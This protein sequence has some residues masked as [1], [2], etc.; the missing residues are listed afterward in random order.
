MNEM[1]EIL[2]YVADEYKPWVRTL[3]SKDVGQI[4]NSI[5]MMPNIRDS[6][7]IISKGSV[8]IGKEGENTFMQIITKY[9]SDDYKLDNVTKV[10]HSGDF[11]LI[12][13]S[14]KTNI[15]YK[16]LI[17]VKQYTNTVPTREITK[18]YTDLNQN[19]IHC[20]LFISL[21]SK[22]CGIS[23]IVELKN[24]AKDNGQPIPCIFANIKEPA[25]IVEIIK[26]LFHIV[27]INDI[28]DNNVYRMDEL[29]YQLS[30]LN[31]NIEMIGNCKLIL[32][33]AK[34]NI[35]KN[36]NDVIY[37]IMEC[38]Y[39]LISKIARITATIENGCN[40]NHII[41][42]NDIS[43]TLETISENK[44]LS[45]LNLMKES[46]S[47]YLNTDRI[48]LLYQIFSLEWDKSA[49]DI[50]K[51]ICT[52]Y[53]N[54]N[55]YSIKI[56]K[57]SLSFIIIKL[58]DVGMEILNEIQS[59]RQSKVKKSSSCIDIKINQDNINHIIKLIQS[60]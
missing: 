37:K 24:I 15:S 52:L 32:T 43:D 16:M 30:Q 49:L 25:L 59:L 34:I 33:T 60:I 18:F 40:T 27:E 31:E 29:T 50:N 41:L 21:N 1:N 53:K 11:K 23:N 38:E 7:K 26:L 55:E 4:L 19:Q 3:T 47:S 44:S 48:S 42:D 13:T 35:E 45:M 14:L 28:H 46:F 36:L 39:S 6:Q 51:R 10:G 5:A 57:D 12:W 20:G 54:N 56:F 9:L 8:D 22:I 58:G 2:K 17:E